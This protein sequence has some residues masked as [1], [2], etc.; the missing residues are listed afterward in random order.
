[1]T[2]KRMR[3]TDLSKLK[4]SVTRI[5]TTNLLHTVLPA[6][7][8]TPKKAQPVRERGPHEATGS[9]QDMWTRPEYKLGDGDTP[10][11]QRPGSD[12]RHVKSFGNPT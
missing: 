4:K 11:F 8:P 9:T 5:N 1:M 10:S 7:K 6:I 2:K 12:H 3:D